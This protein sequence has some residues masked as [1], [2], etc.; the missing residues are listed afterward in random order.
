MAKMFDPRKVLKHIANPLLRE[1]F[2]RRGELFDVPWDELTE[3]KIE[4]VFQ[5]LL[6]LPDEKRQEIQLIMRDVNELADHRGL[7]VLAEEIVWRCPQR[8]EEFRDQVSR[9]DKAMWVY[10]HLPDGFSEAALF[11]RADALSAGRYWI[12]RNGLP[13]IAL[14]VDDALRES[15]AGA[16]TSFYGPLQLRGRQCKV[17]HY[18]RAGNA[19]YFFAYLDD[20]P[21]KHLVFDEGSDEPM[22]RADRYAFEVVFVYNRDEGS[23][24]LFAQGGQKVWAPLQVHFCRAVL[25]EEVDPADPVRPSYYLDRLLNPNFALPTDPADLVEEARITRLRFSPR[26]SGGYI[27]IKADA[28]GPPDDIHHKIARHIKPGSIGDGTR[29]MQAS[30][31]LKF[32]HDGKGRQ[33]TMTFNVTAPHSCDLKHRPDEQRVVGERCLRLWEVTR[34]N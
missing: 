9:H 11:A 7:A 15:L 17:V 2:S 33:Q 34:D 31:A 16:L 14:A 3:H 12:K 25:D 13:R 10:L 27:E 19:D 8:A 32:F 22:I 23:L 20:Y 5:A 30:F 1:F 24:E 4:P 28:K 26:G 21:D 29:V 6:A 18:Q